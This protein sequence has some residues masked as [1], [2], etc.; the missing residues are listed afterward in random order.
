MEEIFDIFL[1]FTN[2]VTDVL[3]SYK[4]FK[5]IIRKNINHVFGIFLKGSKLK[6]YQKYLLSTITSKV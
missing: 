4:L 2:E 1:Q 3:L 5:L 6:V